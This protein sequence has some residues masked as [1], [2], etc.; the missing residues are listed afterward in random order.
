MAC[1]NCGRLE[2]RLEELEAKLA[3]V[4]GFKIEATKA[5]GARAAVR[6][7][8]ASPSEGTPPASTSGGGAAVRPGGTNQPAAAPAPGSGAALRPGSGSLPAIPAKK[9]SGP[10]PAAPKNGSSFHDVELEPPP[11][12]EA[13]KYLPPMKLATA[14]E[15][16]RLLELGIPDADQPSALR[17]L[18]EYPKGLEAIAP[19]IGKGVPGTAIFHAAYAA[20]KH[21]RE[22][23]EKVVLA[24]YAPHALEPADLPHAVEAARTHGFECAEISVQLGYRRVDIVFA[25][26]VAK[27]FPRPQVGREAIVRMKKLFDKIRADVAGD[28]L[29]YCAMAYL[30]LG[31][32]FLE[33]ALR[34][35]HPKNEREPWA[36]GISIP[37][38]AWAYRM[39]APHTGPAID[40]C[41]QKGTRR[42]KVGHEVLTILSRRFGRKVTLPPWLGGGKE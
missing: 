16:K 34:D 19:L 33:R 21:G 1:D 3:Q 32:E 14:E 17:A 27:L 39:S 37:L 4:I 28:D 13:T 42:E 22:L 12:S 26:E 31:E 41:R 35:R 29:R 30:N 8:A 6:P 40:E 20:E 5:N 7:A 2:K 18:Q 9:P 11:L 15:R 10:F 36:R 25:A 24:L 23:V 38:I